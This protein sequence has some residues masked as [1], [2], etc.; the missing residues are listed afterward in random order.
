MAKPIAD[1]TDVSPW[2]TRAKDLSLITKPDGSLADDLQLRLD[3]RNR[4]GVRA[5]RVRV[6]ALDELPDRGDCPGNIA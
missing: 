6:H 2:K 5:E 1:S 3:S 4:F